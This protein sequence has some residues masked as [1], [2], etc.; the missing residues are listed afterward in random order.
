M[1]RSIILLVCILCIFAGCGKDDNLTKEERA[2]NYQTTAD[3]YQQQV[4]EFA[5]Q[6]KNM[7]VIPQPYTKE[8]QKEYQ[9]YNENIL[10]LVDNMDAL[11]VL[12]Q[13]DVDDGKLEQDVCDEISAHFE[14]EKP[15]IATLRNAMNIML[16]M[17]VPMEEV[18]EQQNTKQYWFQN[19]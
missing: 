16:G 19:D 6:V 3:Q 15:Q 7:S 17:S 14:E 8:L 2:Q 4:D 11:V 10:A 12:M 9:K 5:D 18:Q 13:Q 1:K